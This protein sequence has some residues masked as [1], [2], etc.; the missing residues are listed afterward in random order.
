MKEWLEP[1]DIQVPAEL[2][3]AVGG[4]P[5]IAQT[6]AQRGFTQ[7][8][9][10]QAFLNPHLYQP[11]PATDIPDIGR[12]AERLD[13]AIKQRETICVWGDF[14]VDGQTST[15][16]LLSTL[17]DL[18]G[19]AR[20]YM[21]SRHK[22]SHGVH[23]P[24]LKQLVAEG[25]GVVLTCDTGITA[26]EP[27]AYAQAQGVDVIV[28][29]H[30]DLP[31]ELPPAYAA[32]NPKML[33][34]DHPLRTLPGAGCAYKLAEE[35][36]DRAGRG[37]EASRHLDLV[38]LGIVADIAEQIG[39]AR[40]LLQLGLEALRHTERLGL[41]VMI[42]SAGLNPL[43]ISEEHIGFGLGPR[44]NALG[45]L[46]DASVGVEL[47]MTDDLT[48]ARILVAQTEGLNAQRKLLTNQV[49]RAAE[50]QIEQDPSL[51]EYGALVLS[52]PTWPA[53]IVGIV[54]SRMAERFNRPAIL[55]ATPP[56]E[57]GRGSARSV[58]GCNITAAITA[59]SDMLEGFGGHP[60]A[61]GL[62]IHPERIPEFRR[63]LSNTVSEMMADAQVRPSIQ[64]DGYVPLS[65]LSL[66]L[67]ADLER[68]S[69]F[70]AGNPAPVLATR[71]LSLASHRVIGRSEDH[72]LLYVEDEAGMAQ[73]TLWWHGAGSPLPEGRFDL[74][75]SVR[76]RDY[77]G[78]QEIQVEWIDARPREG[79]ATLRVQPPQ[80]EVVDYRRE[81]DPRGMLR[82][83]RAR[84]EVQVWAE[85]EARTN[86]SGQDRNQIGPAQALAIWTTPPGTNEVLDVLERVSPETVYL[87]G[88][89]PGL[90]DAETFLR[91]L[92]GLVKRALNSDQPVVQISTL[93]AATAQR[94]SSVWAGLAWLEDRGDIAVLDGENG[95]V[96]LAR[97]DQSDRDDV[98]QAAV[99]IQEMLKETAAYRTHFSRADKDS[100]F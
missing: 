78:E 4:H 62:A 66:D 5:L 82:D 69:P 26:H 81:S 71:D 38:A 50:E 94:E 44:L 12:A 6:L 98:S 90:D 67:V 36:Y 65:D 1:P 83:L 8:N 93:A 54:A 45:R 60:M 40:Y 30:H 31:P 80:I 32:S 41:Q 34:S 87:F 92:A 22:E 97:G 23:L 73:K 15:A 14:D 76:T 58:E 63:A 99:Q 74:A 39:D 35:L 89:D 95:Q 7:V 2:E 27:I 49:T 79:V 51:L 70:G 29:D 16:I 10:A 55:I 56:D 53:G 46:A 21:P 57:L 61:A 47:L 59:H 85:G 24:A 25:V 9:A 72:L 20:F 64:I 3:A 48:R 11:S 43:S 19:V 96:H 75:Y 37:E 91:R 68:L 88:I 77:R 52:H 17:K 86:V 18:G 13:L 84:A 33:P 42:K 100:L 28:T